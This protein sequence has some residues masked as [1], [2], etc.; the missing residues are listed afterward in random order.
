MGAQANDPPN[1]GKL[2]A[3]QLRRTAPVGGLVTGRGL[4]RAGRRTANRVRTPE[5]AAAAVSVLTAAPVRGS[6]GWRLL[7]LWASLIT[8][9][10]ICAPVAEADIVQT[11]GALGPPSD[12]STCTYAGTAHDVAV[13]LQSGGEAR[14]A[15]LHLPP[16]R[17]GHALALLVAFHGLGSN[18]ARF[19]RETGLDALANRQRFAVLYPSSAGRS[20]AISGP[21]TDVTFTR[22]L[23]ARVEALTCIDAR[24]LYVT[25]L[26]NGAGM[27]ARLACEISPLIAGVVPVA[28]YY[29]ALAQCEPARPESLLEIHGTA[30]AVV[31]YDAEGAYGGGNALGYAAA[32]AARDGCAGA[33]TKVELAAHAALYSWNGCAEGVR[34][35]QLTLYGVG[36][37]LPG[38]PG[39]LVHAPGP[40][41]ISGIGA[42]WSFLAPLIL[43]PPP[44]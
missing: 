17:S 6:A 41:T 36:H 27:A 43:A 16:S 1:A 8:L 24:R 9:A 44:A 11:G 20:W 26:S 37:G 23:L 2:P 13:A 19:E 25:G 34:V 42:I 29:G 10:V 14:Q 32:W 39:A 35:E 22:R 15:V 7:R 21:R 40:R 38:A 3:G 5:P 12:T 33:P 31:P 18:A 4:R 30:D 28:G